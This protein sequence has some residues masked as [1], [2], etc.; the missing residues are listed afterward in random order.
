MESLAAVAALHLA[1]QT[2]PSL[3][4]LSFALHARFLVEAS[5]L[6]FLQDALFGHLLFKDLES[7]LEA[8][9]NLD[10]YWLSKQRLHKCGIATRD[11]F[12]GQGLGQ[13]GRRVGPAFVWSDGSMPSHSESIPL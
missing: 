8:V 3:A 5:P 6:Q 13:N 1:T 11:R 10:F 2:L 9:T 12:D 7:F 4:L